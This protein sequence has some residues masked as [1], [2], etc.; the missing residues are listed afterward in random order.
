MNIIPKGNLE[1]SGESEIY[2]DGIFRIQLPSELV[3]RTTSEKG[4]MIFLVGDL[5]LEIE[6]ATCA[7]ASEELEQF[8]VST[9]SIDQTMRRFIPGFPEDSPLKLIPMANGFILHSAV[10]KR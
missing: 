5:P 4:S 10:E 9:E 8:G 3:F 2:D 1:F 7:M 6:W